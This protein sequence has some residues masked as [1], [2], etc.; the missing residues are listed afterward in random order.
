MSRTLPRVS[1]I[2]PVRN[3]AACLAR[4]LASIGTLRYPR[5]LVETI[6]V[7]NGSRDGSPGVAATAGA[8]VL[9][10]PG[11]RVAGLRNRGAR[12]AAG[13]LLAFVDADHELDPGWLAAAV[14]SLAEPGAG[15]AGAAYSPPPAAGWVQRTYD[16]LRERPAER[17]DAE[18]LAS[19]NMAVWRA[20]FDAVGGFDAALETCEDVD[21]CR[22][23]RLAGYA[24]VAEPRMRSVHHGDPRTLGSVFFGELWRGRDN[25]RVSLRAPRSWRSLAS[26]VIPVLDL[27]ALAATAIFLVATPPGVAWLAGGAAAVPFA[28]IGARALRMLRRGRQVRLADAVQAVLVAGAYDSGRAFA[29]ILGA[30]YSRRR[31]E[32]GVP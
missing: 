30:A 1:F 24:V 29:V 17:R 16:A 26:A 14:D 21:F 9:E 20:A 12:S 28:L 8:R 4:C 31:P 27:A 6:V 11:G 23:L 13:A 3:D 7:D 15:A 5:D 10:M 25:L 19:G 18:W 2:V 22:R 32:A